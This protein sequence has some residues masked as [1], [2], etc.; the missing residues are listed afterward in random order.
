MSARVKIQIKRAI[1]IILLS[2][3]GLVTHAQQTGSI[4][5]R[6]FWVMFTKNNWTPSGYNKI[7][8]AAEHPATVTVSGGIDMTIDLSA[9]E[10]REITISS[11]ST[12]CYHIVSTSDITVYAERYPNSEIATIYPSSTL[13]SDYYVQAYVEPNTLS[14]TYE[15]LAIVAVED[16]T[17]VV[18]SGE[19]YHNEFTMSAG[20]CR[21][22]GKPDWAFSTI[23]FITGQFSGI[24]IMAGQ[25]KKIAVFYGSD[26]TYVGPG[27]NSGM[28]YEQAVP[29]DYWGREFIVLPIPEF[30]HDNMIKI[31]SREDNCR[32]WIDDS[33]ATMINK[34]ECHEVWR[35]GVSKIRTEKP[36][37]VCLYMSHAPMMVTIPPLEKCVPQ[38]TFSVIEYEYSQTSH[39]DYYQTHYVNIVAKT[40]GVH[41]MS[42]DGQSIDTAFVHF[43][44]NYS[45]AQLH[46][47]Q[48]MHT[49][50]NTKG[51]FN[52][53]VTGFHKQLDTMPLFSHGYVV[54]IA[55]TDSITNSLFIDNV[56][57]SSE[58]HICSGRTAWA[59]LRT[60]NGIADTRWRLD[61]VDL[62]STALRLPLYFDSPGTHTLT[63][64][65]HGDC[66]KQ[67]CDSLE[68]TLY[69]DPSYLFTETDR[70]CTG[71][72]YDWRGQSLIMAGMYFDSLVTDMGCD[73]IF[74]ISLTEWNESILGI[75]VDGDCYSHTYRLSTQHIDTSEWHNM[76]WSTVPDITELHGHERDSVIELSPTAITYVS[77][78]A[79]AE[80]PTDSTITLKPITW[81]VAEIN[82]V[83][84]HILLG[85]QSSFDAY[86][87]SANA[88]SRE[89]AVN[90]KTL[91]FTGNPL[92]YT[93]PEV[94]D[95]IVVVLTAMNDYCSDTAS[96]VIHIINE[97]IYMPNVFTPGEDINNRFTIAA[98][99]EIEGE[100]TIYNREG[101]RVF[102][103][104]DLATGWDGSNCAQGAYV[105]HLKYRY[106]HT[107]N[108]WQKAV[109]TVTL[110][111]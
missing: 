44:G 88:S 74:A 35:N 41:G 54:G 7:I 38:S 64:M 78:H 85:K 36:A 58:A 101:L 110:L 104:N 45:Y 20:E 1:I 37:S 105:W 69:V 77:L 9:G 51:L 47:T 3:A 90:G 32:V 92:H 70:I 107:P 65:L 99:E 102:H 24:H 87:V 26:C 95:S 43:D 100:L 29:T 27:N 72:T 40:C 22:L 33:L 89:W 15:G 84:K 2:F 76:Q 63:A 42:L 12:A 55:L 13:R 25:G 108:R 6:D 52:A 16:D 96:A 71:E 59:E 111:R 28:L 56:E 34:G 98:A 81:P 109:G 8:V 31:M 19:D 62:D 53:W 73:S 91:A 4:Q 75:E 66:C 93:I 60:N 83:P 61:G 11:T 68:V 10:M 106:L 49:L 5:G 94:S 80:C 30:E 21:M 79:E 57:V 50:T 97:G 39:P 48:G 67:W 82:V 14:K 23:D 17:P 86:D 18:I 103:T 46:I